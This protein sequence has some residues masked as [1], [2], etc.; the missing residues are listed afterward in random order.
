MS[1]RLEKAI[2]FYEPRIKVNDIS[3]FKDANEGIIQVKIE[4]TIIA[5]NSRRNLV[6][7][8]YQNEGTDIPQQ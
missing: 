3:F 1:N 6:Y 5:T 4:Y 8:F 7:P 2:L